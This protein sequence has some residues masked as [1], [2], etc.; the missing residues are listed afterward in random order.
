MFKGCRLCGL[1]KFLNGMLIVLNIGDIWMD[2]DLKF[3]MGY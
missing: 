1:V 2:V 3:I